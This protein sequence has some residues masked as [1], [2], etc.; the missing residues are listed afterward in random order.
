MTFDI[1]GK[2]GYQSQVINFI[3]SEFADEVRLLGYEAAKHQFEAYH[4]NS[5]PFNDFRQKHLSLTQCYYTYDA[6]GAVNNEFDTFITGSDQI[7]RGHIFNIDA[8]MFNWVFGKKRLISY[9]ASFGAGAFE[10]GMEASL[11][12]QKLLSRFDA[13][14]VR[15][16]TGVALCQDYF[17]TKASCV[18]DPVLLLDN[19]D[20]APIY[21][22]HTPS[23]SNDYVAYMLL[24]QAE[25]ER[26]EQPQFLSQFK[27]RYPF[28]NALLDEN[29]KN[30]S[31]ADWLGTLKHAK[32]VITN[33][34][35]GS[36]FCILFKK[37]FI[38][39]KRDDFGGNSRVENLFSNLGINPLLLIESL[40]HSD[41]VEKYEIDYL[42]VYKRLD[43][44]REHSLRFLK[45]ALA[46][47][48]SVKEKL[49]ETALTEEEL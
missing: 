17:H 48:A 25:E 33:S 40:E 4:A 16:E 36:V 23:M 8:Y 35:H 45:D 14:S 1:L 26:I 37:P 39:I 38:C 30:R 47:D 32:Y 7:W 19:S 22:S 9:A 18:L 3:P 42:A 46:C 28:V 20:Y 10:A 13:I 34:F 15:E 49:K 11:G 41:Q 21:Q 29:G 43:G 2:L 27:T 6:L 24:D 12:T 31:F 5:C 44:L